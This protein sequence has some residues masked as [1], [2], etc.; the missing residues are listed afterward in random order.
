MKLRQAR[1]TAVVIALR[2]LEDNLHLV[3][4]YA[5]EMLDIPKEGDKEVDIQLVFDEYKLLLDRISQREG[6]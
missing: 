6:R 2:I 5:D 3:K 4:G 1:K